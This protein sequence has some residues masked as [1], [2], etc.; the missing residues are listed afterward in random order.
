MTI[1]VRKADLEVLVGIISGG[2]AVGLLSIWEIAARSG[3]ISPLLAPAP[4]AVVATLVRQLQ[5]GELAPHMIAT[6]SRVIIGLVIGGTAGVTMGILMGTIPR[7]R[8]I[9]DPFISA[10]R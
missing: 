10:F 7:V 9:A 6:L 2:I 1:S 3:G 4:T 8:A 5:S